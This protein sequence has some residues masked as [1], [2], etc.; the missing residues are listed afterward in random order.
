MAICIKIKSSN[1]DLVEKI[2][3]KIDSHIISTWSYDDEF[4]FTHETGQW[5]N[6]AW[7]SKK[8]AEKNLIT[9]GIIG[10]RDEP[11]TK[12]KYSIFHAR[13]AEMLLTHFDDEIEE[14]RLTSMPIR[15]IDI[16]PCSV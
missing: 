7:I 11:M 16:L 13:F 2:I 8:I 15:E 6:H 1:V 3:E 12:T 9:F 5:R 4:D 14:I 10:R